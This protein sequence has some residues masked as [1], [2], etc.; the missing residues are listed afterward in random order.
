MKTDIKYSPKPIIGL[1]VNRHRGDFTIADIFTANGQTVS[2]LT[3]MKRIRELRKAG[4]LKKVG[5]TTAQDV[6]SEGIYSFSTPP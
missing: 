5:M 4:E 6:R 1:T 3:I 2:M